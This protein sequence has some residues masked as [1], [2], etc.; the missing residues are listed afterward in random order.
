VQHNGWWKMVIIATYKTSAYSQQEIGEYYQLPSNERR[1]RLFFVR[2]NKNSQLW[3]P[4]SYQ[5]SLYF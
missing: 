4:F 2:K 1:L 5:F 3:T